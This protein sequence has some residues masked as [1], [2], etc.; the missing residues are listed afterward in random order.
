MA[1]YQYTAKDA[2]GKKIKSSVVANNYQEFYQILREKQ[3]FCLDYQVSGDGAEAS[4]RT[5]AAA[6]AGD[7]VSYKLKSKEIVIFCRQLSAMLSAGIT[8]VR[9][10]NIL[11]Q[12]AEN[13][14]YKECLLMLYE[15]VQKGQLLSAAM[16]KLGSA[17]PVLLINM[18]ESGET[19][20]T[21]DS[22]MLKMADH[23][24]KDNRLKN[25][26][27]NAMIYPIILVCMAVA[28]V[29]LLMTFI[30]PKFVA[31]YN[32]MEIPALT[33][34]MVNMSDFLIHY[35]WLCLIIVIGIVGAVY[36]IKKIPAVRL[37]IDE[38]K[39]RIPV[40]GKLLRVV[41]TA[42]CARTLSTLYTSGVSIV[43]SLEIST[44]VLNNTYISNRMGAAIERLKH[45]ESLGTVIN[46]VDVFD[47]M[48]N[49]MVYI[50]EESGNLGTVLDKTASYFD[51]EAEN[52]L[53]RMVSL[54]EP[55]MI[56]IL[57]VIV[58]VI[59]LSVMLPMFGMYEQ[60]GN[61]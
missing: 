50:G 42:R 35:W 29:L 52:A 1:V 16:R 59:I 61:A 4:L 55:I 46:D 14:K 2:N 34:F 17:F 30:I 43:E 9:A 54:I 19:G 22:V 8:I 58:L 25:Q 36:Y 10:L 51:D 44:K 21:L 60:V 23:Y 48:F 13:K 18:I 7:G 57:G 15:A 26:V 20:G 56:V 49:S 6:N 47:P 45:G 33:Q 5:A 3:Q 40:F 24:E 31:M 11:Y 12:K 39:I 27:R 32:G 41:Y 37:T 28:V 53:K 38:W